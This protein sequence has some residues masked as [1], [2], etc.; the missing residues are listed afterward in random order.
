MTRR[1]C[2]P[3][4]SPK[5]ERGECGSPACSATAEPCCTCMPAPPVGRKPPS[6]WTHGCTPCGV[7]RPRGPWLQGSSGFRPTGS[8]CFTPG[9]GILPTRAW[10]TSAG[11]SQPGPPGLVSLGIVRKPQARARGMRVASVFGHRRAVRRCTCMPAPPVGRKPPSLWTHGCTPCGVARPRGPCR[12]P[13]ARARGIRI[14]NV[15]GRRGAMRRCT[16]MPAPPGGR[17]PPSL[18][19]HGRTSGGVDGPTEPWLQGSS[20]FRPP[21][22]SSV[23]PCFRASVLPCFR[24]YGS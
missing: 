11:C 17:K 22:C 4:G 2:R 6:L 5:R 15:F 12:K 14:A 18:W 23:L 21:G 1:P 7:A 13:Q 10:P 16:C 9:L 20:G 3:S 8:R 24:S 19:T